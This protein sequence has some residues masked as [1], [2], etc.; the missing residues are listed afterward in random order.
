MDHIGTTSLIG[1]SGLV[2][3]FDDQVEESVISF[4]IGAKTLVTRVGGIIGVGKELFWIL[5]LSFTVPPILLSL[6][7]N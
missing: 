1:K 2:V 6:I 7:K 4:Q 3:T 5:T